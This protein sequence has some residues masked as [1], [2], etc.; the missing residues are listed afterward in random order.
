VKGLVGIFAVSG[1]L[2]FSLAGCQSVEESAEG[3]L[4]KPVEEV[5]ELAP[6]DSPLLRGDPEA[7]ASKSV[8]DIEPD[9]G[10]QFSKEK[11]F[12]GYVSAN[13]I[14]VTINKFATV[15]DLNQYLEKN[16]L[17]IHYAEKGIA[18]LVL[19]IPEQESLEA[20]E[21]FIKQIDKKVFGTSR[22]TSPLRE[23]ELPKT[24]YRLPMPKEEIFTGSPGERALEHLNKLN[25]D[26]ETRKEVEVLQNGHSLN[27][28]SGRVL[29]SATVQ[30]VNHFLKINKLSIV[31]SRKNDPNIL[32]RLQSIQTLPELVNF[33]SN[34]NEAGVIALELIKKE[35]LTPFGKYQ[36]CPKLE[37]TVYV[38]HGFIIGGP[39]DRKR[40]KGVLLGTAGDDVIHG[41]D[42]VDEIFGKEGSDV[43]CG[44]AGDDALVGGEG[45]D[46]VFGGEG[47]DLIAGDEGNDELHGEQGVDALY[48]DAGNDH[49]F[50]QSEDENV[51][52]GEG[53]NK[54]VN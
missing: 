37:P 28:L 43:I 42:E 50:S 21:E 41:T 19:E 46:L 8:E 51:D 52:G 23:M 13:F 25:F 44:R 4:D 3:T 38:Q 1:F 7:K 54:I 34:L 45:D 2:A 15:Q 36:E 39:Q 22:K 31:Q 49:I 6:P 10:Y 14:R 5:K 53:E 27:I 24:I 9:L 48:G 17:R 26:S 47:D 30:Q 35:V 33:T 29:K 18:G 12:L 40:Y 32:V 20:L 11:T 16:E